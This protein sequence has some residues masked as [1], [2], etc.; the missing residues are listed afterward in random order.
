MTRIRL[1]RANEWGKTPRIGPSS[2]G[3]D[4]ARVRRTRSSVGAV[5]LQLWLRRGVGALFRTTC[6]RARALQRPT[7]QNRD[8]VRPGCARGAARGGQR[9][10]QHGLDAP[11]SNR[12]HARELRPG[13]R[14]IS[15]RKPI[16]TSPGPGRPTPTCSECWR[17]GGSEISRRPAW[18]SDSTFARSTIACSKTAASRSRC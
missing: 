12:L 6:G 9:N 16:A 11:A 4:R 7:G 2:R 18:E 8:V 15:K 17:F 5:S 14:A 1:S 13:R 3:G 10:S